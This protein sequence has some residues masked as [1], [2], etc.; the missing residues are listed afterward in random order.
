MN[1]YQSIQK[2]YGILIDMSKVYLVRHYSHVYKASLVR[3]DGK[4][5]YYKLNSIHSRYKPSSVG[6][7]MRG[8]VYVNSRSTNNY[9]GDIVR[10]DRYTV[11]EYI[12]PPKTKSEQWAEDNPGLMIAIAAI[13]FIAIMIMVLTIMIL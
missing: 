8:N 5:G 12:A 3:T 11:Q 1:P 2:S 10:K 7:S 6:V 13:A 4:Y 9:V